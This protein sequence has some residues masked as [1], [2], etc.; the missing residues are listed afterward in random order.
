MEICKGKRR[1]GN[2][3]KQFLLK[4]SK[5]ICWWSHIKLLFSLQY[6]GKDYIQYKYASGVFRP[7]GRLVYRFGCRNFGPQK[8]LQVFFFQ[9]YFNKKYVEVM[10]NDFTMHLIISKWLRRQKCREKRKNNEAKRGWS[11]ESNKRWLP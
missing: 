11:E 5:G 10:I 1:R 7:F 8:I 6:I 4:N 2:I 9:L 3:S